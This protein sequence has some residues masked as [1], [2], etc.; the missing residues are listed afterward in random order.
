MGGDSVYAYNM[1]CFYALA[2]RATLLVSS[3]MLV[4]ERVRGTAR[5]REGG[6]VGAGWG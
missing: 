3:T 2:E 5:G 6:G 4:G 1:V